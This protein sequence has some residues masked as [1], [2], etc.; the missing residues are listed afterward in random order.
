MNF[1][2]INLLLLIFMPLCALSGTIDLNNLKQTEINKRD[3]TNI[4]NESFSDNKESV[5]IN[6]FNNDTKSRLSNPIPD[7]NVLRSRYGFSNLR[8]NEKL[9]VS[10]K[11]HTLYLQNKEL[12]SHDENQADPLFFGL[13]PLDR[14]KNAG[15]INNASQ[16]SV[17]EVVA[18]YD[19]EHGDDL[20]KFLVAIYHR[21]IILDPKFD[22]VGYY[23]M[24]SQ[25]KNIIEIMMGT[26][27]LN[28]PIQYSNYPYDNQNE[29][30]VSFYP[31]QE[32]PNPMPGYEIVGY[33][34][35]FQITGG[36]ILKVNSFSLTDNKG[37]QINGKILTS[38][39]DKEVQDSQF[40]FIP[41]NPLLE[42]EKYTAS[43]TGI[44]NN[45]NF[46]KT[47]SFT[48]KIMPKPEVFASSNSLKPNENFQLL[49]KNIDSSSVSF[50]A[51][52]IGSNNNLIKVVSQEWGK[53]TLQALP[54]C[55]LK[56]GCEVTMK[57]VTENKTYSTKI[58]VHQ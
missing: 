46:S 28:K 19:G 55:V 29:I 12:P 54:G 1:K 10:A 49:Y 32:L 2:Q 25:N 48:T 36:H 47:W 22:E 58:T 50:K 45:H 21:F 16:Y 23:Y 8:Y 9:Y 14:S 24:K 18:F 51:A 42:N 20:E 5:S 40:A 15:Y 30:P 27:N 33:P 38:S 37:Q 52:T 6:D 39:T 35:S 31:A 56:E 43:I 41:Y 7:L 26:T 57:I 17:G 3:I 13:N 34:I 11:N 44:I 4:S 53:I